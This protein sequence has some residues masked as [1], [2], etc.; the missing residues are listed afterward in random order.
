MKTRILLTALAVVMSMTLSAATPAFLTKLGIKKV[1]ELP[2]NITQF[3]KFTDINARQMVKLAPYFFYDPESVNYE[4]EDD[5][6]SFMIV[7]YK[8]LGD[9]TLVL[10]NSIYG[11]MMV[12]MIGVYDKEGAI[13]DYVNLGAWRDLQF[14]DYDETLRTGLADVTALSM[15]FTGD[16][17]FIITRKASQSNLKV[18]DPEKYNFD[19][20]Y[21]APMLWTITT[22]YTYNILPDNGHAMIKKV[23]KETQGKPGERREVVEQGRDLSYFSYNTFDRLGQL[24][25]YLVANDIDVIS[26]DS[27]IEEYPSPRSVAMGTLSMWYNQ[28]P[29]QLFRWLYDNRDDERSTRVVALFEHLYSVSWL[30]KYDLVQKIEKIAD[31]AVRNYLSRLTS[32]W[33]P[34]NAVG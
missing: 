18:F 17:S 19:D 4:D 5:M 26:E 33:G 21:T 34:A 16:N 6:G 11:D 30:D 7:G 32:Q 3:D 8:Q 1:N 15:K 31:P 12:N 20:V 14:D 23:H 24:N 10:F 13:T 28:N 29:D 25:H 27:D 2:D 9:Y 22:D